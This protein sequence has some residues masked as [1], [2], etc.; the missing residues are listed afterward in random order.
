ML[1]EI[2]QK[3]RIC[4]TGFAQNLGWISIYF[5]TGTVGCQEEMKTMV[6]FAA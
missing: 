4:I 5:F 3:P 2:W 1:L 6:S